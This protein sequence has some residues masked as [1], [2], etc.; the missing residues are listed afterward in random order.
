MHENSALDV[1]RKSSGECLVL[2]GCQ[3]L[4]VS[5]AKG[6]QQ[7]CFLVGTQARSTANLFQLF[8]HLVQKLVRHQ[9][10]VINLSCVNGWLVWN[11]GR[12]GALLVIV[13][14]AA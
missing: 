12:F 10:Y 14:A 6:T 4:L 8:Q 5:R 3:P 11:C 9:T 1:R 2:E 7:L 13:V